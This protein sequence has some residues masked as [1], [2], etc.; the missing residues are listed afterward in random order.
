L[1]LIFYFDIYFDFYY[2]LIYIYRGNGTQIFSE[3]RTNGIMPENDKKFVRK[4]LGNFFI[5]KSLQMRLIA[6]I[7]AAALVTAVVSSGSLFLVYYLRYKT[8]VAYLWSQETNEIDK[9]NILYLLLPALAI[10]AAVGVIVAFGIGLYASRKYAVPIYKIEQWVAMLQNG[11][12]S[13]ILR[14]REY[15]EMK[16]LSQKCNE[17]GALIRGTL[18]DIRNKVKSMQD[19]GAEHPELGAIIDKLDAMELTG[20]NKT[21]TIVRKD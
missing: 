10:S 16:D 3:K 7:V 13:A 8:S 19:G 9:Q 12:M 20:E 21:V 14:F 2:E 11:K 5:K 18:L 6:K 1:T 4:P 17:L 15:E